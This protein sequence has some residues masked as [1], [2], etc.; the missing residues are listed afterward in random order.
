MNVWAIMPETW[1][2]LFLLVICLL[3]IWRWWSSW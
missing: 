3:S 2:A 1:T